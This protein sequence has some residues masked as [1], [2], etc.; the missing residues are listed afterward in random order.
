MTGYLTAIDSG[1]RRNDG[2][3][4]GMTVM[5]GGMTVMGFGMTVWGAE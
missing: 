5:V 4:G 3:V 1:L 2:R